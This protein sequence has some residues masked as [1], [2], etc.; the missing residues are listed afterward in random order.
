MEMSNGSENDLERLVKGKDKASQC[1]DLTENSS[2]RRII[3]R[4]KK[5]EHSENTKEKNELVEQPKKHIKVVKKEKK[6]KTEKNVKTEKDVKTEKKYRFEKNTFEKKDIIEKKGKAEKKDKVEKRDK[7]EKKKKTEKKMAKSQSEKNTK[8][9]LLNGKVSINKQTRKEHKTRLNEYKAE[10]GAV[11]FQNE[12]L[13]DAEIATNEFETDYFKI[14]AKKQMSLTSI[15]FLLNEDDEIDFEFNENPQTKKKNLDIQRALLELKKVSNNYESSTASSSQESMLLN[16]KG[17]K[18]KLVKEVV[19]SIDINISS[20]SGSE[21]DCD[22]MSDDNDILILMD[23]SRCTDFLQ[24]GLLETDELT[25]E[26]LNSDNNIS[27]NLISTNCADIK[28]VMKNT[29]S[30]SDKS[31]KLMILESSASKIQND[32]NGNCSKSKAKGRKVMKNKSKSNPSSDILNEATLIHSEV[33]QDQ[34]SNGNSSRKK[35]NIP[36]NDRR[37]LLAK[38]SENLDI[39]VGESPSKNMVDKSLL[40]EREITIIVSTSKTSNRDKQ[41]KG[42]KEKMNKLKKN[43][44]NNECIAKSL[45]QKEAN[46]VGVARRKSSRKMVDCKNMSIIF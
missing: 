7:V 11:T 14:D 27:S 6:D 9:D 8:K 46:L 3:K 24:T 12:T 36:R 43:S 40:N 23:N 10:K 21:D 34:G 26:F 35:K 2:R 45:E 28:T 30:N 42:R 13:V 1:K 41:R 39:K 18:N 17:R 32:F 20:D 44:E 15:Q 38:K 25:E 31:E 29:N 33:V 37:K 4:S 16:S 22:V 19:E 5:N